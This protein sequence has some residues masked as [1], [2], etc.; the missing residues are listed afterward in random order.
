MLANLAGDYETL[1]RALHADIRAVEEKYDDPAT[2]NFLTDLLEEHEKTLW[3][4]Q[5]HL[6]LD[7][8]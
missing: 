6:D 5:V 8:G 7:L 1:L 3:M 4:L 2:C